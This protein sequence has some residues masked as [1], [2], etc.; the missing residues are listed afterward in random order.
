MQELDRKTTLLG[1]IQ[2]EQ[3]RLETLLN[4]LDEATLIRSDFIGDWS[5]KIILAHLTWWEQQALGVLRGE[6]DI[7]RPDIEPWETTLQRVNAQTY[8]ANR[9]RPLSEIL[10]EWRASH[11][12]MLEAVEALSE[13]ALA[14]EEVYDDIAGNSFEHFQEH[15]QA[16]E[17]ALHLEAGGA[18]SPST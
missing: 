4:S 1:L 7:Y 5:I 14:R 15:R 8:E 17:A 6:P 10:R 3:S 9:D 13:D 11:Q 16:I 2:E 18:S 12:Q